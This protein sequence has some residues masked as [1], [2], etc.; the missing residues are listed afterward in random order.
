MDFLALRA[1][2]D[3]ISINKNYKIKRDRGCSLRKRSYIIQSFIIKGTGWDINIS[4]FSYHE[5]I[6]SM[7]RK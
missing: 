3:V 2:L 5:M 6:H 1:I 7:I 4:K